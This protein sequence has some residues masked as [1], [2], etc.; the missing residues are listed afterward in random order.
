MNR[1]DFIQKRDAG[2]RGNDSCIRSDLS[3][4]VQTVVWLGGSQ[5]TEPHLCT[6]RGGRDSFYYISALND[7]IVEVE[8]LYEIVC[9][10]Q[11]TRFKGSKQCD[12]SDSLITIPYY[13]KGGPRPQPTY[14]RHILECIK[15][16][17]KN[18]EVIKT[19]C[20]RAPS[21]SGSD[22]LFEITITAEFE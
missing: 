14:H 20:L 16:L 22:E 13:D 2:R 12:L 15:P 21:R 8:I 1:Q 6:N 10:N 4:S 3:T 11:I 5:V 18:Q 19:T 7:S 9:V 17:K